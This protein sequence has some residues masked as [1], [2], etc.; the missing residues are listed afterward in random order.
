MGS[1]KKGKLRSKTLKVQHG[2]EQLV[3]SAAFL[4]PK[5]VIGPFHRGERCIYPRGDI[6]CYGNWGIL[7]ISTA[8]CSVG[9]WLGY[10]PLAVCRGSD[11]CTSSS[12]P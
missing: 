3:P 7:S 2:A 6:R 10:R 11:T 4:Q 1:G 12:F 9:P 5:A 8:C